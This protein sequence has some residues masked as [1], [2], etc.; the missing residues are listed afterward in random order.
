MITNALPPFLWFI[1]YFSPS[2]LVCLSARPQLFMTILQGVGH[3]RSQ[4]FVWGA[5]F[6]QNVEDLFFLVV[7]S[8]T[9]SKTTNSSS[10]Y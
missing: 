4:D 8:K 9:R 10:K 7:V 3:R 2:W 5:L 6:P 1:V